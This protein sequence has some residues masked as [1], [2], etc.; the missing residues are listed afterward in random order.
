MKSLLYILIAV[1]IGSI[2]IPP[3]QN[4]ELKAQTIAV[5]CTHDNPSAEALNKSA[6]IIKSRLADF[7]LNKAEVKI[8]NTSSGLTISLDKVVDPE[9]LYPLLTAK[10]SI[11]FFEVFDRLEV[12]NRLGDYSELA[13]I[14]NIPGDDSRFTRYSGILGFCKADK[15]PEAELCL[16]KYTTEES[17]AEVNFC[18]SAN[19]DQE[20]NVYLYVLNQEAS[21]NN[22]FISYSGV[23]NDVPDKVPEL[24]IHF[25]EPGTS[26]WQEI[27]SR[28]MGKSIVITLDAK[29]L[30]APV[31]KSEIRGGKCMIT[32][33]F[34]PVEI[35]R[36]NALIGNEE[37][38]LE[39]KLKI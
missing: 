19:P 28:N 30:F 12:L 14:L 24:M 3:F 36:L 32:G 38:P 22:S 11:E 1:F 6:D 18:W 34:T 16:Q 4:G 8:N 35:S 29:V 26:A 39:F 9:I 21:M 5:Q 7:G 27:T 37:L 31:V 20:G 17:L 13:S 23:Q 2:I 15:K 10:G 33:D 25:D